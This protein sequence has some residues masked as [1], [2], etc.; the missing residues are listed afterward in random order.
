MGNRDLAGAA[1]ALLFSM[2]GFSAAAFFLSLAYQMYFPVLAGLAMACANVADHEL[3]AS[4]RESAGSPGTP[5]P[6]WNPAVAN[7]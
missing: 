7:V 5:S 4:T 3:R 2:I 6:V 1:S